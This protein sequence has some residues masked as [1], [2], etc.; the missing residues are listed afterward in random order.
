MRKLPSL[1][2]CYVFLY[3]FQFLNISLH[4]GKGLGYGHG[5]RRTLKVKGRGM[6]GKWRDRVGHLRAKQLEILLRTTWPKLMGN[7]EGESCCMEL[8][9]LEECEHI[10]R[11]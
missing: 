4:E 1:S 9:V 10:P 7:R 6:E 5:L 8:R 2:L 3:F 11:A